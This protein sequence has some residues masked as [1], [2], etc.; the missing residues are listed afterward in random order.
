MRILKSRDCA[1]DSCMCIEQKTKR[2]QDEWSFD[3]MF[4]LYD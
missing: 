4:D 2:Q 3:K 1:K